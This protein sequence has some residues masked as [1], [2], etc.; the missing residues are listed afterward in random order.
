MASARQCFITGFMGCPSTEEAVPALPVGGHPKLRPGTLKNS[1]YKL[2]VI[3]IDR[4]PVHSFVIFLSLPLSPVICTQTPHNTNTHT[5]M[6]THTHIHT[7]IHTHTHTCVAHL[8]VVDR[9]HEL[10]KAGQLEK[11]EVTGFEE[12]TGVAECIIWKE[13]RKEK[14]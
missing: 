9:E 5:H 8:K 3:F 11:K 4:E 6:E 1:T 2:K 13:G 12:L 10:R 7:H 14:R